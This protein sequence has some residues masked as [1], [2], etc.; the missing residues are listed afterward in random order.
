MGS[1]S[2]SGISETVTR[3]TALRDEHSSRAQRVGRVGWVDDYCGCENVV[4]ALRVG[5]RRRKKVA[6]RTFGEEHV[7]YVE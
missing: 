4:A 5:R 1:A 6:Q 3:A 7:A 2:P